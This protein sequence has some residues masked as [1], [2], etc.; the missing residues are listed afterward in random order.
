MLEA[1]FELFVPLVVASIIDKGIALHDTQ[2]I[3]Q[4]CILL[5]LLALIGLVCALTA[6][7]FSAKAA[8]GLSTQMRQDLFS[9]IQSLSPQDI[10]RLGASTL[11]TRLTSDIN[12]IQTGINLFLR[13]FLRSPFVVF[14]AAF[15]A[16]Y[17][18]AHA[19]LVFA[20]VIPL[21]AAIVFAIMLTT[22]PLYKKVQ[23]HLDTVSDMVRENLSGV[24]VI[25]AFRRE[26]SEVERFDAHNDQLLHTQLFVGRISACMNPLTFVIV[27]AGIIALIWCGALQVEIGS[28]TQGQ[29]VAL[30]NYMSQILVELVKL[31]NLIITVT[32]ALACNKRIEEIMQLEP[33][34]KT[35]NQCASNTTA[36]DICLSDVCLN[37]GGAEVL[38][39]I[40]LTI[41]ASSTLGILGG[42]GSGKSILAELIAHLYNPSSGTIT[43]ANIDVANWDIH[44]L[45]QRIGFVP[46]HATLLSGTLKDNLTWRHPQAT[47]KD[48][49]EALEIASARNFVE[50]LPQG[51]A[52]HVSQGGTN[53]SGGQ[54]QRLTIARALVGK[55]EVLILDDSSS[56]LDFATER[57]LRHALEN[58]SWKPTII[59][60]S[61]RISSLRHADNIVVMDDGHVA[62]Q[63]T[64]EQLL[65]NC[66]LYQEIYASQ[67]SNQQQEGGLYEH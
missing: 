52:T 50:K 22:A 44:E 25:R 41:E 36:A 53:F 15:M 63:G 27:N 43:Y 49:I 14:G 58:L 55:P 7:Y 10:D 8:V 1:S 13:L 31:A 61:Q 48:L 57:N 5:V 28:L 2:S 38:S 62:C 66:A 26:D 16:F 54:R 47:E 46:Q 3:I 59:V 4:S 18:D 9:H 34:L 12:Q 67:S 51:L 11:I 35:G 56:A 39:H 64:H 33:S 30:V 21:L 40:N 20:V 65:E 42:T 24:R 45:R 17:V 60:V 6:Q 37:F 32:K 29:V 19:A 23:R